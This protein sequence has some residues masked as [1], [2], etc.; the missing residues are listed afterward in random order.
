MMAGVCV[1][2]PMK[3]EPSEKTHLIFGIYA[4]V[5][6]LDPVMSTLSAPIAK[7]HILPEKN[8]ASKHAD[9]AQDVPEITT[10]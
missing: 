5:L 10:I 6:G 1:L 9:G 7:E 4:R 8:V 3:P 2:V